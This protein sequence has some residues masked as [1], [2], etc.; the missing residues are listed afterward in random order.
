MSIL[1]LIRKILGELLNWLQTNNSSQKQFKGDIMYIVKADNPEVGFNLSFTATDSEGNTVPTDTLNVNVESDNEDAVEVNTD[2]GGM[3]GTVTFGNPGLANVNV[4]VEDDDGNL[5][6]S[7]G[8][9]FTVT[10]GDP[11]AIAGGTLTFDGL[12]E[13]EAEPTPEANPAEE[14]EVPP[15]M[16]DT[17]DIENTENVENA[18]S[19][20][21]G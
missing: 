15:V 5:L 12:T 9:Q 14:S 1:E 2:A 17:E 16:E 18:E 3:S 6:G 4:T 13:A 20:D 21:I 10:V 8:A 7:F 11:K 19:E